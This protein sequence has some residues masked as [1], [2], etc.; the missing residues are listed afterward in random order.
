MS[1]TP[2]HVAGGTQGIPITRKGSGSSDSSG[3]GSFV[4][5]E[6]EFNDISKQ[7]E[8]NDAP[9]PSSNNDT[10]EEFV[11]TTK[12]YDD[13]LSPKNDVK[14]ELNVI[15]KQVEPK[16]NGL[17][18]FGHGFSCFLFVLIISFVFNSFDLIDLN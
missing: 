1:T 11:H 9:P 18:P 5:A 13:A 8:S 3:M 16:R 4:D 2:T 17:R 14:K 6:K 15:S 7:E 12:P 10:K